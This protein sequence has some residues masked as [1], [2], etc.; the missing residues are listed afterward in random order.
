MIALGDA[1]ALLLQSI[2][3]PDTARPPV[4]VRSARSRNRAEAWAYDLARQRDYALAM[5]KSDEERA[6]IGAA[7]EVERAGG[8]DFTRY[9]AGS[10]FKELVPEHQLDRND[11]HKV[12]VAFDVIRKG[13]FEHCRVPRR[14][15]AVQGA[16]DDGTRRGMQALED[17][18]RR[19]G[20]DEASIEAAV[21]GY[22]KDRAREAAEQVGGDS[23]QSRAA[24]QQAAP[25]SRNYRA[26][27]DVLLGYAVRFGRVYP[28]LETIAR[29]AGV[30]VRTVQNA[31][32]WLRRFGFVE[33]V[34]RVV[35]ERDRLGGVRCRQTSNA[36]RVGFP[37]GIGQ[38]AQSVFKRIAYATGGRA[39]TTRNTCHPS[40][41]PY[42]PMTNDPLWGGRWQDGF[43]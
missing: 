25:P 22:S 9:H 14:R 4:K 16:A 8:P 13:M 15:P 1:Q 12:L 35:R 40:R 32:D 42:T 39:S 21:K 27:L 31:I 3:P 6:E 24:V 37:T 2:A 23:E 41:S 30:S 5:A 20:A 7:Y 18:L 36:Y 26:V 34:R 38:L 11:R 29:Q 17:T 10:G 28:K 43:Q 19:V 33:R